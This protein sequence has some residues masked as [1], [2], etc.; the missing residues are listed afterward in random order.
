MKICW[1]L[2]TN[3]PTDGINHANRMKPKSHFTE[4]IGKFCPNSTRKG[5]PIYIQKHLDRDI[6]EK[7][8]GGKDIQNR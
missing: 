7:K 8:W 3:R 1:I 2:H 5:N 4:E 6:D